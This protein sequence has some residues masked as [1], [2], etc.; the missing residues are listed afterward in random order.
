VNH[1]LESE[2]NVARTIRFL[3]ARLR[4]HAMNLPPGS[5]Q[6]VEY[7]DRGQS[8]TKSAR[9]S[10]SRDLGPGVSAGFIS[11]RRR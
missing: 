4:H 3:R 7:D 5:T 8:L 6:R 9:A 1:E 2:A 11:E 10:L